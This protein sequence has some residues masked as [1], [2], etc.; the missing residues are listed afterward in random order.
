[1]AAARTDRRVER[2][3]RTRRPVLD[4]TMA[5]ASVEGLERV[6]PGRPAA[7]LG[8]GKSGGFALFG[9]REELPGGFSDNRGGRS[10]ARHICHRYAGFASQ[11]INSPFR[12]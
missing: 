8:L 5:I 12:P 6:S 2:G 4:R 10:C 3:N 7:E 1:M 9:S 11:M